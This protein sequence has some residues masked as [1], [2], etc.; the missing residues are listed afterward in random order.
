MMTRRGTSARL[1]TTLYCRPSCPS[2]LRPN[3][4]T[5]PPLHSTALWHAPHATPVATGGREPSSRSGGGN[6]CASLFFFRGASPRLWT[7]DAAP[8]E[9]PPVDDAP[10][11]SPP[12]CTGG[13]ETVQRPY[14]NLG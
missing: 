8:W 4:Y 3:A 2:A 5:T 6:S 7:E 9:A 1:A 13:G 14:N 11:D 12:I 10:M